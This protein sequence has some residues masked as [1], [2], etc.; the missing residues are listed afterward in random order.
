MSDLAYPRKD[1]AFLEKTMECLMLVRKFEE[2]LLLLFGQG[3]IYG[4][5][6]L[7]VGE[8]ATG[9]GS[10]FALEPWDYILST[11]RGHG[12]T[13]A[14]G[15][16]VKAMMAEMLG[17]EAGTNRGR[18]G[19]I[20][21]TDTSVNALGVGGIL[22]AS[23]PVACG[24]ALSFKMRGEKDRIAAVFFGDGSANEGAVHEAMN[25]A[26]AWRLPVLFICTNNGYGMSTPLKKAVNDTDLTKRGYP[27]GIRSTEVDG[28]DVLAVIETVGEARAYIVREERPAFVVEHTYRTCGHSKSDCNRY[29]TKEEIAEWESKNPVARFAR[30]LL[31][32]G[33]TEAELAAMD[34]RTDKA[35][36]EAAAYAEA[37]PAPAASAAELEAE[38][39]DERNAGEERRKSG[40]A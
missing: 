10:V 31:E 32:N 25:L 15:A 21:I 22:G 9:V 27:Y 17:K 5:T 8:E 33:F 29:R 11:H 12:Q 23:C 36:D 1:K 13:L 34:E 16:S 18:G 4:T 40:D 7:C 19:S 35:I 6:H 3:K 38:A 14:K 37:C 24:V 30:S 39:Y 20:H 28:N 2:K 26:A